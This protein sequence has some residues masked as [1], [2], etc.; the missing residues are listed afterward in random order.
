MRRLLHLSFK[1]SNLKLNATF[2]GYKLGKSSGLISDFKGG[3][4]YY[5]IR[6]Y[7][8]MRWDTR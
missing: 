6:D 8:V 3:L 5:M 1:D 7:A 2:L 4:I